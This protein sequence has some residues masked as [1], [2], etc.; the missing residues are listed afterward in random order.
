MMEDMFDN[1]ILCNGCG[2][3]T[4]GNIS[5][6]NGFQFRVKECPKCGKVLYHPGDIERYKQFSEMRKREFNVKLRMVG[7]SFAV[8]IPREIID[9]HS[10][11]REM[12][13]LVRLTLDDFNRLSL[14]FGEAKSLKRRKRE[15]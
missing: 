10:L 7:N 1:K 11:E 15:L 13:S 9:F 6:K 2:V 5:V 4:N 8:T 3:E 14:F 12:D